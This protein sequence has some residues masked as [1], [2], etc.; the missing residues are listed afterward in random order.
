MATTH[1]SLGITYLSKK[2]LVSIVTRV[3]SLFFLL[4]CSSSYRQMFFSRSTQDRCSNK[5]A[6]NSFLE[7]NGEL[8]RILVEKDNRKVLTSKCTESIFFSLFDVE[9][10]ANLTLR[11]KEKIIDFLIE[12]NSD[13][14]GFDIFGKEPLLSSIILSDIEMIKLLVERG[15]DLSPV[16]GYGIE[17]LYQALYVN[18]VAIVDFLI[19]C[20]VKP[21]F[22]DSNGSTPLHI[23]AM[24]SPHKTEIV[25]LLI[26]EGVDIDAKDKLGKTPL[27]YA[28]DNYGDNLINKVKLFIERG[29]NVNA[30]DKSEVSP[31]L[32]A[33]KN[34]NRNLVKLLIDNGANPKYADYRYIQQNYKFQSGRL[35]LI[36]DFLNQ[37]LSITNTTI[38]D[39]KRKSVQIAIENNQYETVKSLINNG[40]DIN[41]REPN[42]ITPLIYAIQQKD[43]KMIELLLKHGADPN[44]SVDTYGLTALY[45]ITR[46]TDTD[47]MEIAQTLANYGAD[48]NIRDNNFKTP[49][50]YTFHEDYT[51]FLIR[52]GANI[53][54]QGK[55]KKG[56]LH[57]KTH[58]QDVLEALIISGANTNI[59]DR[60]R[61]TPLHYQSHPNI[62]KLLINN[63]ANVNAKDDLGRTPLFSL[64]NI[65]KP[66]LLIA[67][68]ADVTVVDNYG[69][70][71]LHF[72]TDEFIAKLLIENGADV[73]IKDN[74]GNTPI[75]GKK[76]VD[77]VRLLIKSGADINVK[78]LEGKTP[79]D[80]AI[81]KKYQD[82]V[83]LLIEY[84]AE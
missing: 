48:V 42:G 53:N 27:H 14:H 81:E 59:K 54:A 62:V 56:V 61:K 2:L 37:D 75:F 29:A 63:G 6:M 28:V 78:N 57:F 80:I 20:G 5:Y 25:E 11:Q 33:V 21:N 10:S 18:N 55:Y 40:A 76:S 38:A 82:V 39:S 58:S 49:I 71:P 77:T 31:L 24:I 64:Q 19:K 13:N 1:Q 16:T 51:N 41:A 36:V 79:L 72:A 69:N 32:I 22:T 52:N 50:F 23:A 35:K 47:Y 83:D 45:H 12:H 70:T 65:Q 84:G 26:D 73:N 74:E 3:L 44:V 46:G 17:A 15:T 43:I 34:R 4:G 68:G 66:Q 8:S 9:Q 67:N 30:K 7:A 60:S